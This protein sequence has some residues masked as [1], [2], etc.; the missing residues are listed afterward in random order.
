MLEIESHNYLKL[1]LKKYPLD[2]KHIYSFGR[3]LSRCLRTKDNCLINSEI[4][5][6]DKWISALLISLFLH[7]ENS[8]V[9]FPKGTINL[10]KKNQ[11]R[12]LKKIGF[13]FLVIDNEIIFKS[14]KITLITLSQLISENYN[15]LNLFNQ[16][17]IF[18]GTENIKEDLKDFSRITLFKKDWLSSSHI[19]FKYENEIIRIY[20]SL[21]EKFFLKAIPSKKY[22]YLGSNEMKYFN[23]LFSKYSFYSHKFLKIRESLKANWACWVI[24][25]HDNFEWILN[26]QPINEFIEVKNLLK[27]NHFIMLSSLRKDE[28][29]QKYL[30]SNNLKVD[31]VINFKSD[32][33]ERDIFIYVPFRQILPNN[34]L[35]T[36]SIIDKCNKLVIF[37]KGLTVILS[38]QKTLKIQL[39]TKLASYHGKKVLLE[40]RPDTQSNKVILCASFDWWIDNLHLF[41]VPEQVIIPLIPIPNIGEPINEMTISFNTKNSKDW[42]RDFML[43]AAFEKLDKSVSPLRRNSGKLII[44]DGR[45]NNR[46]W[47]RDLIEK[48][49]PSQINS[50]LLPF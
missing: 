10:L 50:Y 7:E 29:F 8:T 18:T 47:G 25:D 14:H 40:N 46:K 24:L 3:I 39:A 17:I 31:L 23:Q 48:I 44:L 27:N 6:T 33:I 43:P 38:D 36:N 42:F 32:F 26:L 21:K 28:F 20:E 49:Q 9:I 16:S 15:Y 13:K 45:V 19:F 11:L 35:F 34:P 4:F 1:F 37:G 41:K 30:K 22:I 5:K 2:W 12:E